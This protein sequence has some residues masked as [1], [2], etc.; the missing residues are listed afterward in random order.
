MTKCT[1]VE[2]FITS[3]EGVTSL[4]L[5]WTRGYNRQLFDALKFNH[6]VVTLD[7]SHTDH[8][9]VDALSDMLRVNTS[10]TTLSVEG[11]DLTSERSLKL[12]KALHHNRSLTTL[13]ISDNPL[14]HVQGLCDLLRASTPL[15]ELDVGRSLLTRTNVSRVFQA[16]KINRTLRSLTVG[17]YD[18]SLF[19]SVLDVNTSLREMWGFNCSVP[20]P[21]LKHF[22]CHNF[23]LTQAFGWGN[24]EENKFMV[25]DIDEPPRYCRSVEFILKSG[26][27]SVNDVLRIWPLETSPLTTVWQYLFGDGC[28]KPAFRRAVERCAKHVLAN[29]ESLV[30][31]T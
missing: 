18:A 5:R 19:G 20:P 15:A 28:L 24:L 27:M 30:C 8:I 7:V 13:N 23:T 6:E 14:M 3:P 22:L 16:L 2:A 26:L 17:S 21:Q 10:L 4:S 29:D 1:G 9:D 31:T 12:F 25:G 11:C